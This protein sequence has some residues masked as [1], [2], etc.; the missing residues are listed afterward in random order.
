[1]AGPRNL[2]SAG[3]VSPHSQADPREATGT[4]SVL[5]KVLSF[6]ASH[7]KETWGHGYSEQ[8]QAGLAHVPALL[9]PF[10]NARSSEL[11][12]GRHRHG[13]GP[14]QPVPGPEPL[15]LAS[16]LPCL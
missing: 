6:P 7:S 12:S 14:V 16:F 9:G 1:M 8:E 15:N 13:H 3:L 4:L 2:G 5:T 10:M 11:M